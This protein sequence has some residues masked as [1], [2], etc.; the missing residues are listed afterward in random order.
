[1]QTKTLLSLFS[2]LAIWGCEQDSSMSP[3]S[4]DCA[5]SMIEIPDKA[6]SASSGGAL[7]NKCIFYNVD[8]DRNTGIYT[9]YYLPSDVF[10]SKSS[11]GGGET[12]KGNSTIGKP[13]VDLPPINAAH[14]PPTNQTLDYVLDI[15]VTYDNEIIYPPVLLPYYSNSKGNL[16]HLT[17]DTELKEQHFE[18]NQYADIF[19]NTNSSEFIY[20]KKNVDISNLDGSE[21]NKYQEGV[22]EC[23][24]QD[25]VYYIIKDDK[26]YF[27]IDPSSPIFKPNVTRI[28]KGKFH[29][30]TYQTEW[31]KTVCSNGQYIVPIV[32][33]TINITLTIIK[34]KPTVNPKY[35]ENIV[36]PVGRLYNILVSD[37]VIR[38]IPLAN[39]NYFVTSNQKEFRN[40]AYY[41]N[42]DKSISILNSS[43]KE[44]DNYP[45]SYRIEIDNEE[46]QVMKPDGI[47]V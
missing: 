45:S 46:C 15:Y 25:D 47:P 7:R 5:E 11:G 44:I 28:K 42:Q 38:A 1:M 22:Q 29:I 24:E 32:T 36:F 4:G 17:T 2:V 20:M 9:L 34:G 33:Y 21:D 14:T 3:I 18:R 26:M 27:H 31:T 43:G 37:Q 30:A 8:Y 12:G 13:G 40:S 6:I 23:G 35:D 10:G 16:Q 39:K 19:L 41:I